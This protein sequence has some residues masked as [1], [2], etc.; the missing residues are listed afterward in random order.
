M[1][2]AASGTLFTLFLVTLS[3]VVSWFWCK[4]V[5]LNNFRESME[6][7]ALIHAKEVN[8]I[9]LASVKAFKSYEKKIELISDE[10]KK[11]IGKDNYEELESDVNKQVIDFVE[12]D[13][14]N[15]QDKME[16]EAMYERS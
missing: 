8:G 13:M 6:A 1:I 4:A 16:K 12:T 14:R 5:E 10:L 9:L 3:F 7:I 11:H 2:T 15:L